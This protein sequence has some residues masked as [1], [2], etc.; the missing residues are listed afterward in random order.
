MSGTEVRFKTGTNLS[1]F[2]NGARVSAVG[3]EGENQALAEA[4]Y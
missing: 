4:V 2:M 3:N 1:N